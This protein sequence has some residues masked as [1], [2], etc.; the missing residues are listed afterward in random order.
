MMYPKNWTEFTPFLWREHGGFGT[1]G[2]PTR[3]PDFG[4]T[5]A[6]GACG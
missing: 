3:G 1:Q 6:E 5:P 2:K 4:R